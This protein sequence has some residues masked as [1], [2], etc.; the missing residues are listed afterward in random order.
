MTE[1][2]RNPH[3]SFIWYELLTSD[4]EGAAAFY[5]EVIGWTDRDSGVAGM[6]YRIFSYGEEGVAGM[7]ALPPGAAKQG[8]SPLWAG[9]IGVEDV[10]AIVAR[11]EAAGGRVL[12]PAAD[13]PGVGRIAMVA[14]PQGAS[15]YVMRGASDQPSTSFSQHQVGHAAWNEL[16][17]TDWETACHFYIDLFGWERSTP[18]DMGPMGTYQLIAHG[19]IDI[20]GMFNAP[21]TARPQWLPYFHVADIDVAQ[22]RIG[23]GGGMVVNGPMQVPGGGWI[24]QGT[25]PQGALFAVT[26]PRKQA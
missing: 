10:D 11:I 4:P 14:D 2:Q 17:S 20:G 18:M 21:G 26:G 12:M 7:M 19:G 15:F 24:I 23:A 1:G 25:D 16:H 8:M 13:I 9:Y 3:G 6:N 22:E 5:R